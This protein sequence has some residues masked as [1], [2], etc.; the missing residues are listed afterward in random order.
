MILIAT[1]SE[2]VNKAILVEQIIITNSTVE[3][4]H[5]LEKAGIYLLVNDEK[6]TLYV[7]QA[8]KR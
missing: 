7:G 8:V 3:N 6:N 5:E 4:E 2:C 1:I